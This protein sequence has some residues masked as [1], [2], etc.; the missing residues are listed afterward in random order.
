V[1]NG[2]VRRRRIRNFLIQDDRE[3]AYSALLSTP[4]DSPDFALSVVK[5]VLIDAVQP[6]V[7][8]SIAGLVA[9]ARA[10]DA[11]DV[12]LLTRQFADAARLLIVDGLIADA[13]AVLVTLLSDS[14]EART[15]EGVIVASLRDAG[16]AV[17]QAAVLIARRRFEE[18]GRCLRAVGLELPAMI[19][20]GVREGDGLVWVESAEMADVQEASVLRQ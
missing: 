2:S 11:I 15:A 1:E 16:N 19:V 10:D 20:E 9:G 18:A 17:G 6:R 5:A 4:T 3:A 14:N 8:P 7:A 12:A 13:I